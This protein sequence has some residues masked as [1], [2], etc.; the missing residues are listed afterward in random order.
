[1]LFDTGINCVLAGQSI[2][3][4]VMSQLARPR[5]IKSM[6]T[7]CSHLA[8][9]VGYKLLS[10]HHIF[11]ICADHSQETAVIH[12]LFHKSQAKTQNVRQEWMKFCCS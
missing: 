12:V 6:Y 9:Q 4:N 2:F 5:G 3:N 10:N 7:L 1:M 8:Y 11:S